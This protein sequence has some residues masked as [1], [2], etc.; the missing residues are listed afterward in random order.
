MEELPQNLLVAGG[1]PIGIEIG[2]ALS[3]LGSKVT[4]VHKGE[5]ILEH[6]DRAVTEVLYQQLQKEGIEFY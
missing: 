4:V 3:R 2:Q 6:D 1:G 5:M